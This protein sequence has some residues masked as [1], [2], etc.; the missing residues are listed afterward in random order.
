MR[1]LLTIDT[2]NDLIVVCR[3]M[4]IFRRK[5]ISVKDL[6]VSSESERFC[7]TVLFEATEGEAEHIFNFLRRTEGV[8]HVACHRN[9]A[10]DSPSFILAEAEAASAYAARWAEFLHSPRWVFV[11]QGKALLKIKEDA[12]NL[13]N[14]EKAERP[15]IHTFTCVKTSRRPT[16][17]IR[18]SRAEP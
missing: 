3:L 15:G 2:E 9:A 4:N 5:G 16:D 14:H 11:S 18:V 8:S 6:A 7:L 17:D 12:A 1:W 10:S 13:F